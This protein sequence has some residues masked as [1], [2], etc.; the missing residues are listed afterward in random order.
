ME[1]L[2]K[3]VGLVEKIHPQKENLNTW[4]YEEFRRYL[5]SIVRN[6]KS[7]L[8]TNQYPLRIRL[9]KDWHSLFCQM[10]EGS[11][12]R[13]EYY[14]LVGSNLEGSRIYLPKQPRRGDQKSIPTR[15]QVEMSM[16]VMEHGILDNIGFIHSHPRYNGFLGC[17][18]ALFSATDLFN[19]V[20]PGNSISLL[21]LIEEASILFVFKTRQFRDT[22]LSPTIFD[23]EAFAKYWYKQYGY[24][25]LPEEQRVI[26][27]SPGADIWNMHLGISRRHELVYYRGLI[28]EDLQKVSS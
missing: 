6:S 13:C 9:S 8:S 2:N 7:L 1:F 25:F 24:D 21:G 15:L 27:F 3:L 22:G 17:S 11:R 23:H 28:D 5:L 18:R 19:I 16:R 4:K 26:P 10:A 20:R 14:A 12:D